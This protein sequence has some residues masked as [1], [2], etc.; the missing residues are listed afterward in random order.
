MRNL[1]TPLAVTAYTATSALGQGLTAQ[2]D[3]LRNFRNGLRPND[4][5]SVPLSCWIGRVTGVE[6][7][8]LPHGLASWEC[9]NNRLAWLGLNQDGFLDQVRA[10]RERYGSSRVAVLLGTSTSSIGASEETYRRLDPDGGF[11][12]DM[13]RPLLHAPHSL[14][15]FVTAA[16][17]LEGP[18]L[19]VSTACSSSAKVFANA[20]RMIRLGL[21][22]AA[23]VGRLHVDDVRRTMADEQVD[24]IQRV[25]PFV[26]GDPNV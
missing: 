21:I 6:S 15:A 3:G 5:S 24:V 11:P 20:E 10:A 8:S 17:A 1:M 18:G 12:D 4:F 26:D 7:T 13:L 22:D 25:A 14:V 23:E 19:T 16:L 9:R 2:L